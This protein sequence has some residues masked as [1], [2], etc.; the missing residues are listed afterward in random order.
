[1]KLGRFRAY[2]FLN[3]RTFHSKLDEIFNENTKIF[4]NFDHFDH[5]NIYAEK[6]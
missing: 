2:T 5:K 6:I 4:L 1:M 3:L